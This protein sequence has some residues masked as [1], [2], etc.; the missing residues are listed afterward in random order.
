MWQVLYIKALVLWRKV[1]NVT[2]VLN[3]FLI[4]LVTVLRYNQVLFIN[5]TD[6]WWLPSANNEK[7]Y[8]VLLCNECWHGAFITKRSVALTLFITVMSVD[9]QLLIRVLSVYIVLVITVTSVS[10]RRC[11]FRVKCLP[12][13]VYNQATWQLWSCSQFYLELTTKFTGD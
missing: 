5:S 4:F 1:L 2:G 13:T 7:A 11:L 12:S 9:Q 6:C 3:N 8:W 10:A